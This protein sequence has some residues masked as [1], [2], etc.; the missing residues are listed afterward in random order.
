[1]SLGDMLSSSLIQTRP[2][3]E[4]K[5]VGWMLFRVAGN[6]APFLHDLA[7]RH[8]Q[9]NTAV[10]NFGFEGRTSLNRNCICMYIS[11]SSLTA[12]NE[13]CLPLPVRILLKPPIHTFSFAH[14]NF[15]AIFSLQFPAVNPHAHLSPWVY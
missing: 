14:L 12:F 11:I 3:Y 13:A 5:N 4:E 15:Q 10:P 7:K 1:M 2:H 8:P 6:M 9:E